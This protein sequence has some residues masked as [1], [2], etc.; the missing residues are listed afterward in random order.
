MFFV[1]LYSCFQGLK[2]FARLGKMQIH[3]L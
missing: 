2:T 1:N 3:L